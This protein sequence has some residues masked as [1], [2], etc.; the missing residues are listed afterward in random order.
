VL[1][2]DHSGQQIFS[3]SEE[4]LKIIKKYIEGRRQLAAIPD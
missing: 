3:N 1:I 2:A 4:Y